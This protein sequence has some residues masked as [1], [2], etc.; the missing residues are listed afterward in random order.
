ME[1]NKG[2]SFFLYND[3]SCSLLSVMA[4]GVNKEHIF[5][6]MRDTVTCMRRHFGFERTELN[7]FADT[8]V[9]LEQKRMME[10]PMF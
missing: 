2:T 4:V 1:L 6:E 9:R 10:F 3:P 5:A 8:L 7:E